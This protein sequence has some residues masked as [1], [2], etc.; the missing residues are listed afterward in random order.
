MGRIKNFVE[1]TDGWRFGRFLIDR[2]IPPNLSIM[3]KT[4]APKFSK[5]TRMLDLSTQNFSK[6][7]L[8]FE[9]IFCLAV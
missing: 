2:G 4:V 7:A 3:E 1:G 6:K 8:S 9:F 5:P